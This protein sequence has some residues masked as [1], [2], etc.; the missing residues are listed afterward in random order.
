MQVPGVSL[1]FRVLM[2]EN[3]VHSHTDRRG[4]GQ[5]GSRW[6]GKFLGEGLRGLESLIAVHSSLVPLGSALNKV[7]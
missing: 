3:G 7:L 5:Q 2:A 1:G 6:G 4:S